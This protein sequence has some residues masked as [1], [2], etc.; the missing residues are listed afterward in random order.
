MKKYS[1]S[2]LS[3]TYPMPHLLEHQIKSYKSFLQMDTPPEKRKN[4]G[5]EAV[6]RE[7]FPIES[8]DGKW[9]LEYV[10]YFFR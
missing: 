5:L 9:R 4:T 10:S 7:I 2:K 8:I 6:F 3:E 1:F